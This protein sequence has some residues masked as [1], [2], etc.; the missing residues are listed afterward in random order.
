MCWITH[1]ES[2]SRYIAR[3]SSSQKDTSV[4]SISWKHFRMGYLNGDM[5]LSRQ[6]WKH[7]PEGRCTDNQVDLWEA[8]SWVRHLLMPNARVLASEIP[9]ENQAG[10]PFS[11]NFSARIPSAHDFAQYAMIAH[12]MG[13]L[14]MYW[15]YA[16]SS[17][18]HMRRK[19]LWA[20]RSPRRVFRS[21]IQNN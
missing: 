12:K 7:R 19:F 1:D 8:I 21:N 6:Q 18:S 9:N 3:Q 5:M 4:G 13:S 17:I 16:W 10:I 2:G 11:V 15:L 14:S 20:W